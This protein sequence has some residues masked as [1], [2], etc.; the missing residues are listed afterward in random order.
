MNH[1]EFY[2]NW[3]INSESKIKEI[4]RDVSKSGCIKYF[5]YVER[6]SKLY[7]RISKKNNYLIS[8]QNI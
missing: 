3:R 6:I 7:P 5:T 8:I 4:L 1:I 2:F